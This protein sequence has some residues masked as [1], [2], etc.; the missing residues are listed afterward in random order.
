MA[1][2]SIS[3]RP[4]LSNRQ[5][6][7]F[8]ALAEKSAKF[9]PRP[10]QVAPSGCGAPAAIRRSDFRNEIEGSKRWKDKMQL[11]AFGCHN[12]RHK[13]CVPCVA[14][15]IMG[16]IGV[17]YFAPLPSERHA[18]AIVAPDF[19]REV[20]DHDAA[21]LRVAALAE[22]REHAVV[23]VVGD[24]PFETG[25]VAV[26]LVQRRRRAVKIVEIANEPLHAEMV[27]LFEEMPGQAVVVG[28]FGVL[29]ELAAHEHQLLAGMSEHEAII[30]AQIR[31]ALPFVAGHA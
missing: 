6:S 4:L 17:K 20:D 18:D 25:R 14:A 5:S 22:P 1:T 27:L 24:E 21:R 7:T 16:S 2:R 28:P 12:S 10:S 3:F 30:R 8:S 26:E 19:R 31:K 13:P 29:A 9:V 23:G 11:R 15:A